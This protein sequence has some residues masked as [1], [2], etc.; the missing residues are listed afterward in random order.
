MGKVY[1]GIDGRLREVVPAQ[2]VVFV[3]TA[4]SGCTSR[5]SSEARLGE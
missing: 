3:A 4:P 1:D 2:P 5:P